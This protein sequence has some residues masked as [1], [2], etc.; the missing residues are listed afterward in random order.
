M[1]P[2]TAKTAQERFIKSQCSKLA[3]VP[4][5]DGATFSPP[6]ADVRPGLQLE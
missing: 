1:V 3:D 2:T 4:F 5:A 6:G